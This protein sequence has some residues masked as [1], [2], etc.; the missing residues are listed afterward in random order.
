MPPDAIVPSRSPRRRIGA[1]SGNA[2]ARR[3]AVRATLMVRDDDQW[4]AAG[5]SPKRRIRKSA[6]KT[7]RTMSRAIRDD[8]PKRIAERVR[9]RT[10][11]MCRQ[12]RSARERG[13]RQ[14]S[15]SREHRDRDDPAEGG[16][17][18]ADGLIAHHLLVA[19]GKHDHDEEWRR[20]DPVQH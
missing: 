9:P 4:T 13:K 16:E 12:A 20:R 3:K 11:R 7:P 2:A 10:S 18:G 17:D 1:V 6:A 15:E 8:I 14:S 19:R 5:S